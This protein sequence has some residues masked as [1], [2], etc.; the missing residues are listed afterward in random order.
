MH[1]GVHVWCVCGCVVC[2]CVGV[3]G[4]AGDLRSLPVRGG[5]CRT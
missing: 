1:V 5:S 3:P 4:T 2:V